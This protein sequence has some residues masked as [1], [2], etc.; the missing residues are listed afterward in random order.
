MGKGC[1]LISA[2]TLAPGTHGAVAAS[3]TTLEESDQVASA[4]RSPQ[5]EAAAERV[6]EATERQQAA[7]MAVQN[8]YTAR[9]A[10]GTEVRDMQLYVAALLRSR[11]YKIMCVH[12]SMFNSCFITK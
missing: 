5:R 9:A 3:P 12:K 1:C 4:A 6:R 7:S 11:V 2:G 10:L 8:T